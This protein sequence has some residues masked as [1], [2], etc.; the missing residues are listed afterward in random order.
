MKEN[1]ASLSNSPT[2]SR[3]LDQDSL[4]REYI[5]SLRSEITELRRQLQTASTE[6]NQLLQLFLGQ[7]SS[8][9]VSLNPVVNQPSTSTPVQRSKPLEQT[10]DLQGSLPIPTT[11]PTVE[12]TSVKIPPPKAAL[13]KKEKKEA[14]IWQP[15][16]RAKAFA[17]EVPVP[18]LVR[19][20]VQEVNNHRI[21]IGHA[22][23][24]PM[25][26]WLQWQGMV[27]DR[28]NRE[29]ARETLKRMRKQLKN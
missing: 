2:T 3:R 24:R 9:Q 8:L 23:L 4:T 11:A 15:V 1:L 17:D 22:E 25:W 20:Y 7:A 26:E 10:D 19:R 18:L 13:P 28:Q 14:P 16:R 27:L 29:S 12:T 6:K 5:D 21:P